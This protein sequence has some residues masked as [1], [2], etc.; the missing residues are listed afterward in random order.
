LNSAVLRGKKVFSSR[1]T[2][3][4]KCIFGFFRP[5]AVKIILQQKGGRMVNTGDLGKK[6]STKN[7]RKRLKTFEK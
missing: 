3:L 7:V 5:T 4:L 1:Q 6:K 2:I